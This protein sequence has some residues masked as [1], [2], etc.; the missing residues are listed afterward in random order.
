MRT[1]FGMNEKKRNP[2]LQLDDPTDKFKDLLLCISRRNFHDPSWQKI[3]DY[4]NVN[5]TLLK[6]VY[7]TTVLVENDKWSVSRDSLS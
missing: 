5:F 7:F 6:G 2:I 1:F 4:H 3:N